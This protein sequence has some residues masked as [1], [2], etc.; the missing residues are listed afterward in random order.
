MIDYEEQRKNMVNRQLKARDITDENVLK[1]MS[2]VPREK[3]V[4]KDLANHAYDD[5]SLPIGSSQTISQPYMVALMIQALQP[6]E[7]DI[8]LDIGTGS[9]YAAAV[10]SRIVKKVY[11]VER[12]KSLTQKAI[13]NIKELGYDNIHVRHAD[14]TD[15]WPE[16]APY[17][18]IMVAA[19]TPQVPSALKDQLDKGANLVI[20]VGKSI[21]A[22]R[23]KLYHKKDDDSFEINELHPVRF[24]PLVSSKD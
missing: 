18:G 3:F 24:V 23:L 15:G 21:G 1:A 7:D 13:G 19:A 12:K 20:P 4:S 10:A 5:S 14:G 8:I 16:Y 6:K 9:G 22:Q 2:E 17:D 11:S